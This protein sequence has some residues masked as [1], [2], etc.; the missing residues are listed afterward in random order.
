MRIPV[1]L[2]IS[3]LDSLLSKVIFQSVFYFEVNWLRCK[4]VYINHIL[5][6]NF[7]VCAVDMIKL[8][9]SAADFNLGKLIFCILKLCDIICFDDSILC[10]K[11]LFRFQV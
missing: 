9:K 8:M 5:Q 11:L 7:H 2:H 3:Q 1:V 10:I 4:S 6:R